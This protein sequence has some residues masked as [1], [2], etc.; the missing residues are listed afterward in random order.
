MTCRDA[1]IALACAVAASGTA[2]DVT[3][4]PAWA[5]K[6][7][8]YVGEKIV[9]VNNRFLELSDAPELS[10]GAVYTVQRILPPRRGYLG[11]AVDETP[12]KLAFR[13]FDERRFRPFLG[14]AGTAEPR[15]L[16]LTRSGA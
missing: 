12:A 11:I 13:A 5:V 8:W 15:R 4:T 10:E 3:A 1:A 7:S 14:F 6:A 16:P 9:C 2:Y